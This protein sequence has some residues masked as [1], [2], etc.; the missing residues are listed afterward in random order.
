ML[1]LIEASGNPYK[2]GRAFGAATR[3]NILF[4]MKWIMPGGTF[5]KFKAALPPVNQICEKY[6]PRYVEELKGMADG[7]GIDYWR[8]LLLNS[9][10]IR[11]VP[12]GC[13]TI[14]LNEGGRLTLMHNEDGNGLER[15]EDCFLLHYTLENGNS[16]Y[17]FAYAGVLPGCSYSWNSAHLYFSVNYLNPIRSDIKGR[18]SRNFVARAMIEAESVENGIALLK[19]SH[20][21]SGYHYYLGQGER[22]CSI[23]NFGNEVSVKEIAGIDVH[24]NHYIHPAFAKNAPTGEHSRIRLDQARKLIGQKLAP[25]QVLTDRTHAPNAI[26]TRPYEALNTISTVEFSPREKRVTLFEPESLKEERNFV[27]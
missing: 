2:R 20:D 3:E 13:T 10:E 5:E 16:F 27:L 8:L 23:E 4:R 7:A 17:A 22:L 12:S 9:P 24:S 26:C 14:A 11:E 15:A 19:S 1:K 21:A 18:V 25:M 6:Y